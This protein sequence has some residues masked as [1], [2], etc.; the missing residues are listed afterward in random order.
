MVFNAGRHDAYS[1]RYRALGTLRQSVSRD[2]ISPSLP[3]TGTTG[4][5]S[6]ILGRYRRGGTRPGTVRCL[7]AFRARLSSTSGRRA[8]LI[9]GTASVAARIRGTPARRRAGQGDADELEALIRTANETLVRALRCIAS[10]CACTSRRR[11][12]RSCPRDACRSCP[13]ARTIAVALAQVCVPSCSWKSKAWPSSNRQRQTSGRHND[14][15]AVTALRSCRGSQ[16]SATRPTPRHSNRVS[17]LREMNG[18]IAATRSCSGAALRRNSG[19][20]REP[21]DL[22][23]QLDENDGGNNRFLRKVSLK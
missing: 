7:R 3:R 11:G 20:R 22:R 13:R 16:G 14:S 15:V 18:P 6:K 23:D 19:A 21:T 4:T 10:I 5:P 12:G 2:R 9:G 17:L 8:L 1:D